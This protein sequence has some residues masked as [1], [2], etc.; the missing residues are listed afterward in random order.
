LTLSYR[1][2]TVK[3][4]TRSSAKNGEGCGDLKREDMKWSTQCVGK[5]HY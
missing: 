2:F 3:Q 1:F 5:C 4:E